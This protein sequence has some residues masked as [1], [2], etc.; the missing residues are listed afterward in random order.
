MRTRKKKKK[1]KK[2]R[3]TFSTMVSD[4]AADVQLKKKV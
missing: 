4:R 3:K 1:K 2:E